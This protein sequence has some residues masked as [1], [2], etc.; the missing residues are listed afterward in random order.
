ME[1]IPVLEKETLD[2]QPPQL[3]VQ[4]EIRG[5]RVVVVAIARSSQKENSYSSIVQRFRGMAGGGIDEASEEEKGN[6]E[7][8]EQLEM[9]E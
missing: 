4:K 7:Q 5:L 8:T 1:K 3:V 2:G 6:N 9:R